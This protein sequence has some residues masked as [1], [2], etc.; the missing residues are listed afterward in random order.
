MVVTLPEEL[1][2]WSPPERLEWMSW[3]S[4][5]ELLV[6]VTA[7]LVVVVVVVVEL[8]PGKSRLTL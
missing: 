5:V 2:D 7:L 1:L 3:L 8:E 6:V 4:E